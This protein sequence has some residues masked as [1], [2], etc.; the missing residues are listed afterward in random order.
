MHES[1]RPNRGGI[2]YTPLSDSTIKQQTRLIQEHDPAR[3]QKYRSKLL[4]RMDEHEIQVESAQD[5]AILKDPSRYEHYDEI[6]WHESKCQRPK[7]SFET[8][9]N[10]NSMHEVYIPQLSVASNL[11]N[12][13][14]K[15]LSEGSFRMAWLLQETKRL[16]T[17]LNDEAITDTQN[18][19]VMKNLRL[20]LDWNA[21]TVKQVHLEAL[22]MSQTLDSR[23]TAD[24]YG[25]CGTSILVETG[26]SI[27]NSVFYSQELMSLER[28]Q[29]KQLEYNSTSLNDLEDEQRLKLAL[30]MAESLAAMHGNVNGVI[31]NDDLQVFQWVVTQDGNIKLNDFNNAIVMEWNEKDQKYCKFN[32]EFDSVYRSPQENTGEPTDES[33]DVHVLGSILY[34]LLTGLMPFYHEKSH[35]EAV[36]AL[37][38]RKE[39]PCIDPAFRNGTLIQQTLVDIM[40][41]CWHYQSERRPSVFTVLKKLRATVVEY[42]R[43]HPSAD[44]GA[45]DL[46]PLGR[47]L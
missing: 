28:V 34:N 5:L 31:V 7:W 30:R 14:I 44:I 23:A 10:C 32:G 3:Y 29:R 22:V 47:P 36:K 20:A 9:L 43:T 45:V 33:A 40:E 39:T 42:E 19:I 35:R 27:R 17:S 25:H 4:R 12:Y 13:A 21:L 26:Q 38:H 37:V 41:D 15:Y 8:N 1:N 46:R 6:S 24:I 11:Q 18:T 16:S 2:S